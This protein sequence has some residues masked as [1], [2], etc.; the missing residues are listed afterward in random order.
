[1]RFDFGLGHWHTMAFIAALH[2][3]R[4]DA[5]CVLDQSVNGASFAAWV[6]QM[7]V[8]TLSPGDPSSVTS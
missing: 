4:I 5:L 7:L 3:D 6:G 2:H 8:P 1:M